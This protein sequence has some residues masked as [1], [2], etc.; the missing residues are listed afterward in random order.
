MAGF[1]A[2]LASD[3]AFFL[4]ISKIRFDDDFVREARVAFYC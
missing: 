4:V 2:F 1:L 3:D